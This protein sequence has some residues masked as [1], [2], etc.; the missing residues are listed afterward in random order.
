ML[1]QKTETTDLDKSFVLTYCL[2]QPN[3]LSKLGLTYCL[4]QHANERQN[5]RQNPTKH[6]LPVSLQ[7]AIRRLM[8]LMTAIVPKAKLLACK[9]TTN[10]SPSVI[11]D[12]IVV[13]QRRNSFP[14]D[15]TLRNSTRSW[16]ALLVALAN[17]SFTAKYPNAVK[18]ICRHAELPSNETGGKYT[19]ILRSLSKSVDDF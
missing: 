5:L 7:S 3:D 14:S 18:F 2:I 10:S 8:S 19:S 11:S 13:C 6:R 12:V 9:T 15:S 17:A 4:K 16:Y 1:S